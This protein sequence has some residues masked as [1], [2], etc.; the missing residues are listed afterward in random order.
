MQTG[1]QPVETVPVFLHLSMRRQ[2]CGPL[3]DSVMAIFSYADLVDLLESGETITP[4]MPATGGGPQ[5]LRTG[6]MTSD[7]QRAMIAADVHPRGISLERLNLVGPLD[8]SDYALSFALRIIDCEVPDGVDLSGANLQLVDFSGSK[9]GQGAMTRVSL[10]ADRL[11]TVGPL[12]LDEVNCSGTVWLDHSDIGGDVSFPDAKLA[13]LDQA[14]LGLSLDG[15]RIAGSLLAE[16]MIVVHGAIYASGMNVAGAILFTDVRVLH[17]FNGYSLTLD[18]TEVGRNA[19]LDGNLVVTGAVRLTSVNIRGQLI[20]SGAHIVGVDSDG[21]ALVCDRMR[22]GDGVWMDRGMRIAGTIRLKSAHI[23]GQLII[24]DA[25][26]FPSTSQLAIA[27]EDLH[28]RGEVILGFSTGEQVSLDRARLDSDLQILKSYM[29]SGESRYR[30]AFSAQRAVIGGSLRIHPGSEFGG[31]VDLTSIRISGELLVLDVSINGQNSLG[32]SLALGRSQV[33]DSLSLGTIST[34]GSIDLRDSAIGAQVRVIGSNIGRDDSGRSVVGEL[35]TIRSNVTVRDSALRGSLQ[36]KSAKISGQLLISSVT[37]G[38]DSNRNSLL[39]DRIIANSSVIIRSNSIFQGCVRVVGGVVQGQFILM[40][41][42]C[43]GSDQDFD[44]IIADAANLSA[45]LWLGPDLEVAGAIRLDQARIDRWCQI[46]GVTN[47]RSSAGGKSLSAAGTEFVSDVRLGPNLNLEGSVSMPGCR[48]QGSL[49]MTESD[50]VGGIESRSLSLDRSVVE[51]SVMIG[52]NVSFDGCLVLVDVKVTGLI[53]F[54]AT[55]LGVNESTGDSII[56]DRLAVGANLI[57]SEASSTGGTIRL[58]ASTIGGQLVVKDCTLGVTT[59][60]RSLVLDRA[61]ISEMFLIRNDYGGAVSFSGTQID[62]LQVDSEP[63]NLPPLTSAAGWQVGDVSGCLGTERK[64]AYRWLSQD[65]AL[66]PM[67]ELATIFEK[68]GASN[69]SRWLRAQ[70]AKRAAQDVPLVLRPPRWLY[71]AAV[72]HGYFPLRALTWLIAILISSFA[73]ASV[74]APDFETRTTPAIA[75]AR[76]AESGSTAS[77]DP[78]SF[79]L[80][81]AGSW[82][83]SWDVQQFEPFPYVMSSVLPIPG[84]PQVWQPPSGW[85][86]AFFQLARVLA[87]VFAALFLAGVAGLLRK[88]E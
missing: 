5:I 41:A 87:W 67:H 6:V 69:D 66:Q 1:S 78:S 75:E 33:G 57:L 24:R 50:V 34:W 29:D 73:V 61:R 43:N 49:M 4:D 40:A 28:C 36:L 55:T 53:R 47:S 62:S 25:F 14:S 72:G 70:A 8:L 84:S 77:S 81:R 7:L 35:A 18:R 15:I 68:N 19:Y 58:L 85:V 31:A 3:T 45:G 63:D 17:S 20:L 22:V 11:T 46:S 60:P 86:T 79:G 56:A 10:F 13:V 42:R 83:P 27:G 12:R 74:T 54:H 16:S 30:T 64:V 9:I 26:I 82:S 80:S 59:Q 38:S 76:M 65:S 39:L 2:L 32:V 52:P 21:D 88:S 37:A 23:S 71:G 48:I 44:T 51:G